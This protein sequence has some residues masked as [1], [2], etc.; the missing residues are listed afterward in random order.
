MPAEDLRGLD[1]YGVKHIG[2]E[3]FAGKRSGRL[4]VRRTKPYPVD[5]R[6]ESA[7]LP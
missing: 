7:I 6:E 3:H 1:G 2:A 4:R 5:T